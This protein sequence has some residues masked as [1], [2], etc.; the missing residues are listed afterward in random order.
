[1]VFQAQLSEI[2]KNM[3]K[4]WQKLTA[5]ARPSKGMVELY[6]KNILTAIKNGPNFAWGLLGCTPEIRSIAGK[7]QAKITCIDRN[8]D[9]FHAYK[10]MS[11]PSR[12][13][14]FICSDWL[15]LNFKEMF[16]IVLGDGAMSMLP[17]K[18]HAKFLANVH[19]IIKSEGFAVLRIHV[20]APLLFDSPQEIF[21]WYHKKNDNT[22]IYSMRAYLRALWLNM[23]T[24]SLS[25]AEYQTKLLEVYRNGL[26]TFE[27]YKELDV[28]KNH[29]VTVYYTKKEIFEQ[30]I[31]PYFKIEG[32]DYAGDYL[33]HTN[34]PVYFLRKKK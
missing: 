33:I 27:E 7:Y 9:T 5:P 13:E 16:D 12:Y 28:I 34:H 2:Q 24:L 29:G 17:I 30:L 15:D 18:Y 11:E 4:G 6:E 1:M 19:Q 26:I 25:H 22:P 23:D 20:V 32:V 31:S 14:K 3:V 8:P 21:E 10:T